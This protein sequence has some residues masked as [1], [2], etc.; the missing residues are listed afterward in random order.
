MNKNSLY[1][2]E[3]WSVIEELDREFEALLNKKLSFFTGTDAA[4]FGGW[5]GLLLGENTSQAPAFS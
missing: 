4:H 2:S 1:S 5:E 3:T